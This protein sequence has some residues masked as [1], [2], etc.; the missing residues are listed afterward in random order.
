M[1][2]LGDVNFPFS[3][4]CSSANGFGIY[5]ENMIFNLIKYLII[6][7]LL[8]KYHWF[9]SLKHR[10]W[11]WPLTWTVYITMPLLWAWNRLKSPA[12]RLFTQLFIRTQIKENTKAPRHWPL[13]G[14]F[15]GDR[16]IPR[17]NGQKRG[18][19]FHLMTSSWPG[20]MI[21]DFHNGTRWSISYQGAFE[22]MVVN[23]LIKIVVEFIYQWPS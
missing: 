13:C 22:Y 17:T 9:L 5:F 6:K 7:L 4:T 19:Y 23:A 2:N 18:K 10:W 11:W 12:S 8:S 14:E 3:L 15:T 16:W 1:N 20:N 21:N